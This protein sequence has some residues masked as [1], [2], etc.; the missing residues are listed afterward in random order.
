MK[1]TKQVLDNLYALRAGLSVIS[2]QHDKAQAIADECSDKLISNANGMDVECPY[3]NYKKLNE[4]KK[5]YGYDFNLQNKFDMEDSQYSE[6]NPE[7]VEHYESKQRRTQENAD[8]SRKA[9]AHWLVYDESTELFQTN[10][11]NAQYNKSRVDSGNDSNTFGVSYKKDTKR[12]ILLSVLF[13]SLAAVAAVIMAIGFASTDSFK[14]DLG[15]PIFIIGACIVCLVLGIVYMCKAKHDKLQHSS[16]ANKAQGEVMT[17]QHMLENLPQVREN[18][19]KI[20]KEKD[21]KIAPIKESCNDFYM[22]LKK[23]FDSLLDERDWKNLDLVIYE[24]ETRR[25]DSV[26]EALQLVDR[27]L[28]TERIQQTIVQATEQICYEIRRGFAEIK[29]TII[30]CSSVISAQLATVSM[31]L[32]E[33]NEHLADLCDGVNMSNA[34]QAKANVSSAKLLSDVHAIRYYQ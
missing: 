15:F 25:A 26:K 6:D 21:D 10:I 14:D 8:I 1:Q 28:Q 30:E 24:L 9:F 31:Q 2:Q 20:L 7:P 12:G 23:Q 29:A 32:S 34:L 4:L 5:Y 33:T 17:A 11:T 18:A 19:R 13:F 3:N 22:A 27:E 16:A